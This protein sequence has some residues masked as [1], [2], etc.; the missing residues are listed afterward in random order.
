MAAGWIPGADDGEPHRQPFSLV[1]DYAGRTHCAERRHDRIF[2][3]RPDRKQDKRNPAAISRISRDGLSVR[4]PGAGDV[5][6]RA[7][8]GSGKMAADDLSHGGCRESSDRK[9]Q[10][11]DFTV[12]GGT[13]LF[14]RS[15]RRDGLCPAAQRRVTIRK[16]VKDR[17]K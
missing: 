6:A 1:H 7:Y 3:I 15:V 17:A 16:K 2:Y 9:K 11:R 14:Q 5:Y 4:R 10:D 8:A 12:C 13:C